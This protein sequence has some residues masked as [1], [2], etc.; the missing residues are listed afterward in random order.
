MN[1]TKIRELFNAWCAEGSI[2]VPFVARCLCEAFI[3][4]MIR[5]GII[6]EATKDD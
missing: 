2:D 3:M 1:R 4:D 6:K 5:R